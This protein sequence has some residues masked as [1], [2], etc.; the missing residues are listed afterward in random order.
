VSGEGVGGAPEEAG[1]DGRRI[2]GTSG[3]REGREEGWR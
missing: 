1:W 2:E 3:V